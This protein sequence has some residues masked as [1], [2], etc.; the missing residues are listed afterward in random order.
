MVKN[1][2]IEVAS[3]ILLVPLVL[4]GLLLSFSFAAGTALGGGLMILNFFFL[5]RGIQGLFQGK[6]KKWRFFLEYAARLIVL[7]AVI[8]LV[9]YWNK[10]NLGGFVVGLSVVFLG[11]TANSLRNRK[12]PKQP[13][14]KE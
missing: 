11:I 8:Y 6:Q 1:K 5:N 12:A 10:V 3:L 13:P 7:M 2:E 14:A 4:L 9:I